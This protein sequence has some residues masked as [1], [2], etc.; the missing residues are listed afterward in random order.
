MAN[1]LTTDTDL[2]AV[3][4]AI[5]SK[6]GTSEPLFFP[7]GFVDAIDAI[8]AGNPLEVLVRYL[9][10]ETVNQLVVPGVTRLRGDNT[11]GCWPNL[12]SLIMPDVTAVGT[13]GLYKMTNM[14]KLVLP[15]LL[16]VAADGFRDIRGSAGGVCVMDLGQCASLG[17]F[18]INS[19]YNK[20]FIFRKTDGICV[21]NNSTSI[22]SIS[23]VRPAY[24]PQALLNEYQNATNWSAKASAILPIEGSPYEDPDWW[25][26]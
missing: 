14:K 25:K 17:A 5:R 4:N 18:A 11:F 8:E 23:A 1:Y 20:A 9:N 15:S 3:A 7:H 19:C 13:R 16:S 22:E 24:V 6:G 21:A 12:Q 2:T 10:N 26:E